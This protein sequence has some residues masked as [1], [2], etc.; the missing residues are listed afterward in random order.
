MT[1]DLRTKVREHQQKRNKNSYTARY[2]IYKLVYFECFELITIA[3]ARESYLKNQ[4]RLWKIELI[5]RC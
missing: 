4:T 2:N 1:N 3:I 5:K